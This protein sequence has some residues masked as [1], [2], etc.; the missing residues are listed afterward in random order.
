[1]K[2][3]QAAMSELDRVIRFYRHVIDNSPG[4]DRYARWIYGLH[5]SDALLSEY[6]SAG[7]MYILEEDGRIVSAAAVAPQEEDYH[8]TE[9]DVSAEDDEVLCLH[10]FC[11]DPELTRRGIARAVI[12]DVIELG[13]SLGKKTV[14]LDTL[15][16]NLPAQHMYASFGFSLKDRKHWYA[17]NI[18]W[19]D[20]LLYEY[21]L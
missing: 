17:C 11:V 15:A 6:V 7:Y 20:F 1:M 18:G 19:D 12:G 3:R 2:I 21:V 9:W 16:S 4:M 8:E 10:I 14:R 13:R 5:P